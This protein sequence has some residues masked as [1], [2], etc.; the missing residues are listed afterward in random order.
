MNPLFIF[1]EVRI[2][3]KENQINEEIRDKELRVIDSDG[4]QLGIMSLDEAMNLAIE[5]KLD[6]VNIAPTAKPPVARF[7]ITE[8]TDMSFKRRRKRL[9]KNRRSHR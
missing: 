1:W 3:S 5:R 2:I 8:S 7:L 4:T 6:L 9:R